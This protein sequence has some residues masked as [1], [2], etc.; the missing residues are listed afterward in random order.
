MRAFL[1]A[2]EDHIAL[3]KLRRNLPL[4]P[5]DLAELGRMLAASGTGSAQEFERAT[6]ESKG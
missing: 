3:H 5:A 2:H 1:R 4:T 6:T